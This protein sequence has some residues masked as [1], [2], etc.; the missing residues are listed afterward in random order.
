MIEA[1]GCP[2]DP[3]LA[4]RDFLIAEFAARGNTTHIGVAAP[5]G[6][7]PHGYILIG[8]G[9]SAVSSR[10]ATDHLVD[11]V[12]YDRD[13]VR[14]GLTTHLVLAL[15]TSVSNTEVETVQGRTHLVAG[16]HEFGP[17]DYNDPDEPYFGRRMGIYVLMPNAVL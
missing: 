4:V 2:V 12:V 13:A 7:P 1:I 10:F 3:L 5:S 16:R 17:V 9:E 6:D 14:V 11:I 8:S 15:L